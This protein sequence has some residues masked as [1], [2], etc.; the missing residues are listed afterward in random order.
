VSRVSECGAKSSAGRFIA[1]PGGAATT[2][3]TV[4]RFSTGCDPGR[5]VGRW[6]AILTISHW[7]IPNSA[8]VVRVRHL[9]LLGGAALAYSRWFDLLLRGLVKPIRDK[10]QGASNGD[11]RPNPENAAQ[12]ARPHT[13]NAQP[14]PDQHNNWGYE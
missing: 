9:F 12:L 8:L 6:R 3:M 14:Q 5:F 4:G 13:F 7:H 11:E 2:E 1:L 10:P